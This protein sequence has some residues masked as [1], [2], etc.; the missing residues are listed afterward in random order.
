MKN[1]A[2]KCVAITRVLAKDKFYK[3]L[4][5]AETDAEI[6]KL[7]KLRDNRSRDIKRFK[8]IKNHAGQLL[9]TDKE[10]NKRWQDYVLPNTA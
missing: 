6:F 8:Y 10:I 9:T 2:R 5:N 7:A 4:E 3:Q 1:N